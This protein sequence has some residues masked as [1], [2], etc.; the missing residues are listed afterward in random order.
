MLD[1]G[2]GVDLELDHYVEDYPWFR[3][4]VHVF[5][6]EKHVPPRGLVREVFERLM[7]NQFEGFTD[8]EFANCTVAT[9]KAVRP[10]LGIAFELMLPKT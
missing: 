3:N 4:K 6:P 1:I 7:Q 9:V 2:R 5:L 10:A 8:T